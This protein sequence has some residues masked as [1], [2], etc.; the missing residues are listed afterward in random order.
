M[1]LSYVRRAAIHLL[2]MGML[3]L[4][5]GGCQSA[6]PSVSNRLLLAHLPGADF[7]GLETMKP[8]DELK[9]T[10]SLPSKW[11]PL[12][13]N[14]N[15]LYLHRQ[16]KSPTGQTGVGVFYVH[17]PF[18][19]S[20]QTLLWFA[21]TEYSKNNAHGRALNEW[22]DT[23]GRPWFEAENE[24]YHVRGYAVTDGFQAW[25]V[26]SGYKTKY[27]ANPSELSLAARCIDTVVP[28]T[29]ET[30]A[31]KPAVAET[32]DPHAAATPHIAG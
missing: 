2:G 20:A 19:F 32:H 12:P 30:S 31:P 1:M 10:C 5:A 24:K 18:P 26:Y 6:G 21:K 11:T 27:P 14:H 13:V 3:A 4:A 28:Q 17:M 9:V 16:W 8:V 25:I 22:T 29:G 15:P 23:L 7:S